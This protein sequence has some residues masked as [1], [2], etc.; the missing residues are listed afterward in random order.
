MALSATH[1]SATFQSQKLGLTIIRPFL[2]SG[3]P[4]HTPEIEHHHTASSEAWW[5]ELKPVFG[6][7]LVGLGVD[8]ETASII[9]DEVRNQYLRL[10]A[11]H[12][13][14]GAVEVLG[15][16][17]NVGWRHVVVSNHVPELRGLIARLGLAQNF[18]QIF[19]SA[20]LGAEK[21][22]PAVF[23]RVLAS[24]GN[25]PNAWVI[26]DSFRADIADAKHAGLQSILI[27]AHPLADCC[28]RSLWDV[29]TALARGLIKAAP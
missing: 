26:G 19:C 11:W 13:I 5:L 16:L 15:T 23:A 22:N 17:S 8:H 21:P 12:V 25:S 18:E 2:S 4:W 7:A 28:V 6:R 10:D 1:F 29:P 24:L 9:A 27:G 20:E 3:F 14:D